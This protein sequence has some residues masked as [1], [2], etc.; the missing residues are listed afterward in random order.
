M[1]FGFT[2]KFE[3]DLDL[4]GL[5][6][7]H[8]LAIALDTAN[9]LGWK[10]NYTSKSGF[11]AFIGGG[12][13]VTME[14]F[15]VVLH[16]TKVFITS[17]NAGTGM[18]DR[19]KNKRHVNLFIETF[20]TVQASLTEQQIDEKVTEL[21]PVFNSV[22]EDKLSG[23]PPDFQDNVKSFFS[24]FKGYF[25]TPLIID[26]NILVFVLMVMSGVSFFLPGNED[27]LRWGANLRSLTL[28]G[29]WWR[30]ITNIFLHIG[31]IHLLF[32]MYALLYIGILLE[33]YLGKIRFAAAYLFT[34]VIASLTSIYWH[35]FTISAGAS[36]A[37]F[38]M[39]G[40]FLAMLTTNF[41]DKSMRKPFLISISVFVA[42]N[43]MNGMKDGIDNAAHLG[44]L[45]SG[46]VIGYAYYPSLNKPSSAGLKY[47]TLAL[48]AIAF[49]CTSFT[50]YRS[51]PDDY[52][53]YQ[54]YMQDFANN[55]QVALS[56][57][58]L[59]PN[60]PKTEVIEALKEKGIKNWVDNLALVAKM[61]Q[62][63]NMPAAYF[64]KN[65][66]LKRYCEL[67]IKS[68]NDIIVDFGQDTKQYKTEIDSCNTQM[69]AI[70]DSLKND[71]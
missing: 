48:L 24:I 35:S 62:L 18:Y 65:D 50:V 60:T 51:I 1:A 57:F 23:P 31:I 47:A 59:P 40:V 19:G 44:G 28:E 16:E 46:L 53:K 68:Y 15:R 55:E 66:K 36:G 25:V 6:P 34:G 42:Y 49:F 21:A 5:D 11:I 69:T 54:A 17:K 3:Q 7:K 13:F 32:N 27:L 71:N 4:N 10:I 33:P 9:Q 70:I 12:F 29:Q 2:P 56:V 38:G 37:I 67:R 30:L 26:A 8:Y 45:V 22:E 39:Y 14:E 20:E 63:D 41:I 64:G 58:K 43:L 52:A 61:K